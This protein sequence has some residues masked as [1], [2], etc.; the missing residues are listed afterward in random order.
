MKANGAREIVT[1]LPLRR[2]R[3]PAN[4]GRRFVLRA[5]DVRCLENQSVPRVSGRY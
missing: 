4:A 1:V 3:K 2:F 5:L